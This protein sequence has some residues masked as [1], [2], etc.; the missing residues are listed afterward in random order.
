MTA[1]NLLVFSDQLMNSDHQNLEMSLDKLGH[2]LLVHANIV[3]RFFRV[4][5]SL[6]IN[7]I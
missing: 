2:N 5:H 7:T 3:R 1:D 4:F 6:S